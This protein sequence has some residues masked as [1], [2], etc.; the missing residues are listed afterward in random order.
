M[1]NK[2]LL[3]ALGQIEE[4][5]VE[6]AEISGQ[7]SGK[8]RFPRLA[9]LGAAAACLLLGI[10][11]F[12]SGI[13]KR[14]PGPASAPA[15]SETQQT[16]APA[17]SETQ[18]TSAPPQTPPAPQPESTIL[19]Q[20]DGVT[21]K[22]KVS[23]AGSSN[24]HVEACLA[25]L[26][27]QELFTQPLVMR[28]RLADIR[29][30]EI[31]LEYS[32][33]PNNTISAAIFSFEPISLLHGTL[34][35]GTET[36]RVFAHYYNNTSLAGLDLS[37]RTAGEGREG[38]IML[39]AMEGEY[40][41]EYMTELA[42][43]VPGDNLRF[44]IWEMP[45]G[46]LAY[47]KS[48]FPGL[49]KNWSLDQAE[50]YA[51][52]IISNQ[53]PAPADFSLV[54]TQQFFGETPEDCSGRYYNSREAYYAEEGRDHGGRDLEGEKLETRLEL[55]QEVLDDIYRSLNRLADVPETLSAADFAGGVNSQRIELIWTAE[56]RQRRVYYSGSY[57]TEHLPDV[58][59]LQ[60]TIEDIWH[61]IY[62]KSENYRQWSNELYRQ[63][64]ER[65]L[66]R[67]R[68]IVEA[69]NAA[70]EEAYGP[71]GKPEYFQLAEISEGGYLTLWLDPWSE[72]NQEE[73]RAEIRA[74]LPEEY[75]SEVSFGWGR[76][77]AEDGYSLYDYRMSLFLS[78][79][80]Q[81]REPRW[82]IIE[83]EAF[84]EDPAENHLNIGY[85]YEDGRQ[86][87]WYSI[88][89]KGEE[90]DWEPFARLRMRLRVPGREEGLLSEFITRRDDLEYAY[91]LSLCRH[92][93]PIRE[94]DR[95][96]AGEPLAWIY[97]ENQD[98]YGEKME[99]ILL[100]LEDGRLMHSSGAYPEKPLPTDDS[101]DTVTAYYSALPEADMLH[102]LAIGLWHTEER[103]EV[104]Q[105]EAASPEPGL[106][107]R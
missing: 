54:I 27:E 87:A 12:G 88:L 52:G 72:G 26:T 34:P 77:T 44:A 17:I 106:R 2:D 29:Y 105:P 50:A 107:W 19:Y 16:S 48:A 91:Y 20:K 66:A 40:H 84:G 42:E 98:A 43:Y 60:R 74:L 51:R 71:G 73:M 45:G 59:K 18:Q 28:A 36:V 4:E 76:G 56:D 83:K 92:F 14:E 15:I 24:T 47:E 103:A 33:W 53:N 8:K 30:V 102:L 97:Y 55:E 58:T 75:L 31:T 21:V 38:I 67:S 9:G 85:R 25:Y 61:Y 65:R 10:L 13:G 32:I 104:P 101:V 82:E 57:Y 79:K 3:K 94:E 70:F 93:R 23:S 90:E 68:E 49:D 81:D 11:V 6:A 41:P 46:G 95:Q 100:L 86:S 35:E 62:T 78:I 96:E 64:G 5:M 69:L 80:L 22:E 39:Y 1:N 7:K 89:L 37:L 63:E 99:G